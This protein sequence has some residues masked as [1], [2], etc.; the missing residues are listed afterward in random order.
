M[1][2]VYLILV[3]AL[4]ACFCCRATDHSDDIEQFLKLS[5]GQVTQKRVESI[6]GKPERVEQSR[7]NVKW[8]YSGKEADVVINWG[9]KSQSLHRFSC[10]YKN[11]VCTKFDYSVVGK[12][13]SGT[14]NLANALKLLGSPRDVL[15][16]EST[17]IMHYAYENNILRLFFRNGALVDYT[18]VASKSK[19]D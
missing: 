2:K 4:S 6:F 12:L 9:N 3:T 1:S 18:L 19:L 11:S 7:K 5:P 10:N 16:K 8:Y 15:V 14:M 13:K 17:Q